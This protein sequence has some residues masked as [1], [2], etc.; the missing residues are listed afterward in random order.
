[1]LDTRGQRAGVVSQP[2]LRIAQRLVRARDLLEARFRRVV[3]RVDVR[4]IL[5]RKPLVGALDLDQRRP[6]RQSQELVQ[7]H[8]LRVRDLGIGLR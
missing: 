3:T 7:I 5:P 4:V 6:A 1:M 8:M 2:P